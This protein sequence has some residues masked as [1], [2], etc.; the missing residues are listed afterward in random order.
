MDYGNSIKKWEEFNVGDSTK[1]AK[2]I[3]SA[4]IVIWCGLT[5]DMNPIHLDRE[6]SRKTQFK[7]IIVPGI[8]VLGFISA[9]LGKI[10]GSIYA[11]QTVR[12]TKPVYVN[13]TISAESTIID[14]L[15]NKRM[16]KLHTRCANQ[17]EETV[18]DGEALLYI[19]RP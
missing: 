12:F 5:G 8:Y 4:D 13:D 7:D 9:T 19:P 10:L 11:S 16:L 1:Y 15:E 14:K 3:T 17:N 18:L 2:T 6:Y